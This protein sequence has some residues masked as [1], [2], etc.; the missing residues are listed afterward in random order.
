M[1]TIWRGMPTR[2]A[3]AVAA[4]AS[5]G[6]TTAPRAKRGRQRDAGHDHQ[7]TRPTATVLNATNP[8]DI[9][10]IACRL[11]RKSTSEVRMAAEY[12]SGG[13]SPTRIDMR[14]DVDAGDE[15]DER[16]DDPD[17]DQDQRSR[18]MPALGGTSD[19]RGHDHQADDL[20]GRA[21]LSILPAGSKSF[22]SRADVV[23]VV[24]EIVQEVAAE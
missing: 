24:D 5:G 1:V 16:A 20:D 6:A 8:T 9:S 4:T 10:P 17:A 3:T 14:I 11:A 7:A 22:R 18:Q 15:A 13:S 21:H 19:G 23:S 2:R 12:S